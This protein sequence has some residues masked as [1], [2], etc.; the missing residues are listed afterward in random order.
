MSNK[1]I[2]IDENNLHTFGNNV[3]ICF[4]VYQH[5]YCVAIFN[6]NKKN[7]II[8]L[9]PYFNTKLDASNYFNSNS[10]DLSHFYFKNIII[11]NKFEHIKSNM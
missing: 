8:P 10:K 1:P 4:Y 9:T 6:K 11:V 2:Y 5:K 3:F 7:S